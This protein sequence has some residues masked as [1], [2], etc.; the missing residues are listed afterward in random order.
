MNQLYLYIDFQI[1]IT[2]VAHMLHTLQRHL[3]SWFS[4]VAV[5][6]HSPADV[7]QRHYD[8][9]PFAEQIRPDLV[10]GWDQDSVGWLRYKLTCFCHWDHV[11]GIGHKTDR[12]GLSKMEVETWDWWTNAGAGTFVRK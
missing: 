7:I 5:V 11:D 9:H 12:F 6:S 3:K 8:A 4:G 2:L 10:L 1:W